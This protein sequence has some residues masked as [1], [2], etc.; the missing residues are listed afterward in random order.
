[1]SAVTGVLS[2]CAESFIKRLSM[3]KFSLTG[4][5]RRRLKK[6]PTKAM[7]SEAIK[8]ITHINDC[9]FVISP[10]TLESSITTYFIPSVGLINELTKKAED[11]LV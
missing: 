5:S 6:Y 1:M 7:K 11:F 4:L 3:A 10:E 2:S 9:N 8:N